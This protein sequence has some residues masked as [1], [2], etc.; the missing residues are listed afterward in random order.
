MEFPPELG[1]VEGAKRLHDWFGYWPNFHDAEVMRLH[2]NRRDASTLALHTWEMTEEVD[3]KGFYVL[4]KHVVVEFVMK[5]VVGLGLNGFSHQNV[6]FGLA[7]DRV[8]NGYRVTLE[9]CYGI[10]GTIDATEISIRL[11]PGKPQEGS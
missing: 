9:D 4:R 2:L 7:I 6:V 11:T 1:A 10:S 3:E 5:E 8:E